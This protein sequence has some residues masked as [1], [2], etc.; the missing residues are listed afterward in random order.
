MVEVGGKLV[1]GTPKTH[2]RRSVQIPGFL[3]DELSETV[4]RRARDQL[5]FTGPR[6]GPLRA[7]NFRRDVFNRAA[8]SIARPK[9]TPHDLR[10]TAASLA[11]SAGASVKSVQRLLGHRSAAMTLDVYS[12]PFEDDLDTVAER[13][14][15]AHVYP[16]CTQAVQAPGANSDTNL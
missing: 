8:A 14:H 2:Q 11:I 9:L 16:M 6:G 10:H 13:L 4:D 12:G 15:E 1:T 7:R 3:V 5:V